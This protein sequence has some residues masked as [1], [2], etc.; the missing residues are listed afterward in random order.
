MGA[1]VTSSGGAR[2]SPAGAMRAAWAVG[3]GGRAWRTC[4]HRARSEV[5]RGCLAGAAILRDARS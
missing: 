4:A 2:A 5:S 3:C 1:F